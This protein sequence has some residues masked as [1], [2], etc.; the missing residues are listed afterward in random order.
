MSSGLCVIVGAGHGVSM[1]IARRFGREGYQI[2]LVARRQKALTEYIAELAKVDITAQGF[3]ADASDSA[4]IEGAFD[5]IR[6]GLGDAD[7]LVY[8]A[9]AI[10]TG[11]P[12]E[13]NIEDAIA[14]MRVNVGG[15]ILSAQQVIPAM[16]QR[17]SGTILFTG[18]GLAL[19]PYPDYASLAMGKAALRNLTYSLGAELEA[20]TIQVGTVTI[21]GFVQAGTY[22]DPD[23]IA[24]AFWK[25]HSQAP[26][27]R[28][29]EIIYKQP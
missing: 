12:S 23:K 20:D 10:R 18:G 16:R 7:V 13:L 26:A 8:N 24:E 28:E 21:A 27:E 3:T 6:T 14:D 25:L 5:A 1:G 2:A 11:K 17:K 4:S 15:A 9:A 29:R 22:F 19:N